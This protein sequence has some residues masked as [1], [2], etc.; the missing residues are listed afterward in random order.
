MYIFFISKLCICIRSYSFVHIYIPI[1]SNGPRGDSPADRTLESP[2]LP[3]FD[4]YFSSRR[5]ANDIFSMVRTLWPSN[6]SCLPDLSD[7]HGLQAVT[8]APR[9]K[10]SQTLLVGLRRCSDT[11]IIKKNYII[12][13]KYIRV[14]EF[15]IF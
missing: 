11:S 10:V 4:F 12:I 14:F 3:K 2:K 7:I 1:L 15:F 6:P 5:N 13:C 8:C 9:R